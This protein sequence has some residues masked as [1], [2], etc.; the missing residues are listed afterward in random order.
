MPLFFYTFAVTNQSIMK[1]L[2]LLLLF[3]LHFTTFYAVQLS[4]ASKINLLTCTAGDALY[5]K[6]GHTAIRITDPTN[7]IDWVFNYGIFDFN[8]HNFYYK[9]VKGETDYLL[10]VTEMQYFQRE[11]DATKRTIFSQE[12]NLSLEERQMVLDALMENYKPE[13][14]TYR[15]NF[16]FDN[17]ATRPY[18]LIQ[19]ALGKSLHT[20][21]FDKREDT[22]RDIITHYTGRGSWIQMGI[23]LIFGAD[24]DKVMT[25]E[26]RLFLPEELMNL[27]TEATFDKNGTSQR[28]VSQEQIGTFGDAPTGS[29]AT[30]PKMLYTLL[31]ILPILLG[32]IEYR[33]RKKTYFVEATLYFALGVMGII[34]CFLAFFS[35]HPLVQDNANLWFM[36][37]FMFIPFILLTFKR[38]RTLYAKL[39]WG[40]ILY[41]T[42]ALG[43]W[44]LSPQSKHTLILMS[45]VYFIARSK[46]HAL[47]MPLCFRRKISQRKL[48]T[49]LVLILGC[50][51]LTA[52]N[53]PKLVV[54]VTIDGL[55]YDNMK[56]LER[57]FP[58][59]GLRTLLNEA[60]CIPHL[61]FP[62]Q[63]YGSVENTAM[64]C[65]GS[66]P[67]YHG[68]SETYTFNRGT[69]LVEKTLTDRLE[70]GIGT[71]EMLSP[72]NL[73]ASTVADQLKMAIGPMSKV[74]A[75]GIEPDEVITLAGHAGDG[76]IWMNDKEM[77]WA[78]SSYY[79]QGM[80]SAA[81]EMNSNGEFLET[82]SQEWES[83]FSPENYMR[84]TEIEKAKKGFSYKNKYLVGG[85]NEE[86]ILK[87]TPWANTLAVELAL[88]IQDKEQLGKD[89]H[90]DILALHLTTQTP[91]SDG[92]KIN[93]AEQEDMH[94]RLNQDL[95][96][97]MEQLERRVGK[98]NILMLVVGKPHQGCSPEEQNRY[99]I[100]NG[101]FNSERSTALINT[102]LMAMYGHERWIDGCYNQ[103]IFLNQPL[104]EKKKM[105]VASIQKQVADFLME[106]EGIQTAYTSTEIGV[107]S[108]GQ[109][110][111][112]DRL[113]N[114]YNKQSGGDV[115]FTVQPGWSV[116]DSDGNISNDISEI[117]PTAPLFFWGMDLEKQIL[118]GN[119]NATQ[120]APTLCNW[121]NISY[122]NACLNTQGI[123]L[124]K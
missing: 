18:Y 15:Y 39:E 121:L 119:Y 59:G 17:C 120:I 55:R 99:K 60:T 106:F 64:I 47:L 71:Q 52:Q 24:A 36:N 30:S 9:F 48:F 29:Y 63:N 83:R 7:E 26:E 16:V 87:N 23:D 86:S 77:A 11:Y 44:L 50:T 76:A 58:A 13:N 61:A 114:S 72:K 116:V 6:F 94:I 43:I 5:S 68:L 27:Y 104:I 96:F 22:Y 45:A 90:T 89:I 84:P 101:V 98:D 35:T 75:V 53:R 73:L 67:F 38:G 79:N 19:K 46:W 31:G 91:M 34:G 105:S 28:I 111:N 80:H 2:F 10:G 107:L 21:E 1:R 122:P 69:K 115:V 74:Y 95:G 109:N 51:A 65:T 41:F 3:F 78:T 70:V 4:D 37:P 20:P 108:G 113:R 32:A 54:Q 124:G 123:E 93:S 62:H 112:I 117:N 56:L 92:D 14:R 102:Y 81:Y 40:L 42:V 25:P 49:L 118:Q 100:P 33:R 12:L 110:N 82:A 88:R 66:I 85:K 97:L 8:T 57:Y 103:Q